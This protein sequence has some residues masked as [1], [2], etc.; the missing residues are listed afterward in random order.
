MLISTK[1]KMMAKYRRQELQ[2]QLVGRE[3]RGEG[4]CSI[5]EVVQVGMIKGWENAKSCKG[6]REGT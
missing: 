5:G 2:L 3:L 4:T 1:R 6:R